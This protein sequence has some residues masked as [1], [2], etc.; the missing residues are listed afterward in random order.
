[1]SWRRII[2]PPIAHN[3]YVLFLLFTSFIFLM[4]LAGFITIAF[5]RLGLNVHLISFLILSSLIGSL[6]NI[7]LFKVKSLQPMPTIRCVYFFG[8]PYPIP[9]VEHREV[10][11]LVAINVG[12]AI[13]PLV[14][15]VY[16]IVSVPIA[17]IPALLAT[18]AVTLIVYAFARPV[19]G[20]GIAT[21]MF[22]PPL[23][24]AMFAMLFGG[25]FLAPVVAYVSGVLG[26]LIGADLLNL[27][28]IPKL[29]APIVSIGGAGT[30]DGI[31]LTGLIA[32]FLVV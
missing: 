1:L 26:T 14:L 28:E 4:F 9:V 13:I 31:F 7:P 5:A 23:S 30:F 16:L 10:E 8:I 11:S 3:F 15:S 21:P 19:P 12:G 20:L 6:V 25:Y 17:I 27:K 24:A 29:G 2:Y 32:T 22:I 18:G